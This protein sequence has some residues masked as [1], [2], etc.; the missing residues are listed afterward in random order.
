MAIRN[1][2]TDGDDV[3]RKKSKPVEVFDKKLWELLDDMGDTLEEQN[4]V[5]LAAVQVGVLRRIFI[6]D[7]GEGITEF[8]NPQLLEVNGEQEVPEGCLSYPGQWGLIKRPAYAKI[9][10]QNRNGEWFEKDG[11][12]L[13]AQALCHEYDHLDGISFLDKVER[14][15]TDEEVRHLGD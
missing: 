1:L 11:T 3:L 8:I 10:A 12:E 13:Y 7:V 9:K 15:L 14:R 4:G 2:R 6:V 5:G